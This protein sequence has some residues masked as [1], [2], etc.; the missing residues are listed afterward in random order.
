M[1]SSP[2]IIVFDDDPTGSQTVRGCP[3]LLDFSTASLQ[4]GLADP[5]PLLFLLTNSRALEPEQVRQQLTALCQRLKPLLEELQRPW[6]VVSRGDSTLRGHTPLEL[7]VIRSELGPFAANLLV[8]A[9]PQGGRTTKGGVHLLHGEQLHHSPFALD[10]RF[11]YPSS[12]LPQ[13]LEHKTAGAIPA[14]SV[15]RLK[16]ADSF[17]QLEIGQWAVVDASSPND[18]HV[19]AEQVLAELAKGRKHL[20]QSAASLLNGLSG[21]PSELLEPAEL[22]P[23]AAPGLVLVG[24][25]VPLTDA[26]LADLLGQPGCC[27]VEFSL[28]EPQ[29]PAALTAQLQQVLSTGITPVLFSSRGERPGYTPARQRELAL[30]MAQVVMAL[31]PPLGYVI[32]KGGTTSLTFLQRG[33]Q[34]QQVRLLGQLLPGLS[35]VQPAVPHPRFGRLP[36]ITFPGNLGDQTTLSRCWQ[37]LEA[38]RR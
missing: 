7:E 38:A 33:L 32:A 18:L 24:S 11:G 19:I 23:I 30:Q 17:V 4:A 36:V 9:F 2:K 10:R 12:D 3:L 14:T 27:G 26:Q 6:L 13:W 21:M 1:A 16:P 25:H 5:S 31:E 20:C 35:L 8:P 28:D 22:P 29:V 34:L 15:T 37:L